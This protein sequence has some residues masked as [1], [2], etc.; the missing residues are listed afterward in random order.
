MSSDQTGAD[1]ELLTRLAAA[2]NDEPPPPLV[3]HTAKAMFGLRAL[4]AELAELVEDS[5]DTAS[6]VRGPSDVR[7]LAF[8]TPTVAV[9]VE[10]TTAGDRRRLI[11]Q[12]AAEADSLAID[13]PS[14]TVTT[15]VDPLGRFV[16]EDVPA[17]LVRLRFDTPT[18]AVATSW[19]RI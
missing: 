11:G 8:Q 13:T 6:T 4:D 10:V 14:A 19:T 1:D 9:D 3:I 12:V 18:G 7:L 17:G 5:L 15:E 2:A 16:A